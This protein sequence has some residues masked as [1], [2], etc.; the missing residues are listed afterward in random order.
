SRASVCGGWRWRSSAPIS[1]PSVTSP[2][3]RTDSSM[4]SGDHSGPI[5]PMSTPPA[6][7]CWRATFEPALPHAREQAIFGPDTPFYGSHYPPFFLFVAAA[8]ALLPYGL[9]LAVWQLVTFLLYLAS[10]RLLPT[11]CKRL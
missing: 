4:P 2:L 9:A 6:P 5:S 1:S 3:R 7:T 10:I 8:L 11:W